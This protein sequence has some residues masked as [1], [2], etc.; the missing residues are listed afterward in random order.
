MIKKFLFCMILSSVWVQAQTEDE[1]I[2][3]VKDFQ[4]ELDDHYR[5][6]EHSP[7]KKKE[8]RKFKGHRFYEI[9]LSYRVI[10]KVNLIKKPDTI[11]MPTSAGTEKRYLRWAKLKFQIAG[12]DCEL[13][14]Y[15]SAK[16]GQGNYLF[17]PFRDATSGTE[18]Y[19]GGRYLDLEVPEGDELVLNFNLAYNPY[20]AYTT[21]WFCPLP[22]EENTLDVP[23]KAGLKIPYQH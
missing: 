23:I 14:A 1:L 5:D 20:C 3:E 10:A 18:T 6:K 12:Q 15:K 21:G 8:R 11:V 16:A 7:L 9:D 13:I 2:K 4:Q 19:G 17:I 22:P